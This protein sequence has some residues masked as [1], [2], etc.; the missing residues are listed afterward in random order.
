MDL[1]FIQSLGELTET[2]TRERWNSH[3]LKTEVLKRTNFY[4]EK[5][6]KKGDCVAI[7]HNNNNC[8]F[9]DLFALWAIGA[10]VSCLDQEIGANEF[11]NITKELSFS[12]IVIKRK[13]PE[14]LINYVSTVIILDTHD[15]INYAPK[16]NPIKINLDDP[17]LVLFT[18]GSTGMPKGVVHSL[19]TLQT[20]WFTLRHYV[21]LDV[22]KNTLCLLPTNFGHGLICNALYPLV[23]GQHVVLLPKSDIKNLTNLSKIIDKYEISFM[24][25]VA[26]I[27]RIVLRVCPPPKKNTLKQVHIGSA[28]LGNVLWQSVQKWTATKQVWNVYGITETGSWI[29][30]PING[31]K[32]EPVDG[33]IGK[34]WGA[35]IVIASVTDMSDLLNDDSV[36]LPPKEKGYVWVRT[37]CVM[38]GYW[39]C[40]Q[41][42]MDVLQGSW[43]YTGDIGMLDTDGNLVLTGRERNEINKGGMKISP[44][45][46]DVII[47]RH[48]DV[49][50]A[51]AFAFDDKVLG[52]NIGVCVVLN[53][54]QPTPQMSEILE[55]SKVNLSDYKIPARWYSVE[56]I[57]KTSRGKV[58]RND[59]ADYCKTLQIMVD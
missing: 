50:E 6:V 7:L 25:S 49:L 44:E 31:E 3:R 28:P 52:Q 21:S 27:W 11:K 40:N 57:P 56:E 20:K 42:T 39:D 54:D 19:R 51:C 35:E 16:L 41:Q 33:F 43:F 2:K 15:S 26:A 17:A 23:H 8:F 5:G 1:F 30:G 59:V 48:P 53:S 12:Y 45:E 32:F 22:C 10:C 55:W 14:K 46:L 47:E 4:Y 58:K 29:A 24:S 36:I 38:H 37:P 13:L 9:A 18:S 34:G